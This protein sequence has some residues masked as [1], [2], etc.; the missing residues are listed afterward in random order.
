MVTIPH[1]V[2]HCL[3]TVSVGQTVTVVGW[4]AIRA[5][6]HSN[7]TGASDTGKTS[8]QPAVLHK[9]R[10]RR[11]VTQGSQVVVVHTVSKAQ[12]GRCARGGASRCRRDRRCRPERAG[13]G[14]CG[15][16]LDFY[17]GQGSLSLS[18]RNLDGVPCHQCAGLISIPFMGL[19]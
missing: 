19:L 14:E 3:Q 15:R 12:P 16:D 4:T 7:V 10:P 11:L 18:S 17:R 13:L 9:G 2:W 8:R 6:P 1:P 5:Q